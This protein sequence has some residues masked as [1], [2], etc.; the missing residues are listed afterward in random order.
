MRIQDAIEVS[1]NVVQNYVMLSIIETSLNNI[2]IGDSWIEP[3]E[4]SGLA[5]PKITEMLKKGMQTDLSEM[6]EKLVE[7]MEIDIDN[8][9]DKIMK[10]LPELVYAIVGVVLIFFVIVVLVPCINS[11]MGN[12]LFSA[13]DV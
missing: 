7:Y 11:Y 4:K 12:F 13:A 8:I 5:K 2:L 3:F 9:M 6:M 10:V 1:K